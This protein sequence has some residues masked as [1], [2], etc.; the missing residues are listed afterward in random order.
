MVERQGASTGSGGCGAHRDPQSGRRRPASVAGWRGVAAAGVVGFLFVAGCEAFRPREPETPAAVDNARAI[1]REV[2]VPRHLQDGEEYRVG[3]EALIEHGRNLFAAA[4]TVE[5]GGGRPL[6][7]GTGEQLADRRTPLVFPRGFNRISGMDANSCAGCHNAPFG[8]AAGG[9]D[10]VTNVFVLGQ[11]FDFVT[12][13]PADTVPTRG[14]VDERGRPVTLQTIGNSRSTLGMFGAGF[15][16]MLAR[17]ITRDLQAIRDGTPPG[18]SRPLVSKGIS[19]G[20]IV[21]TPDGRWDASR[22][23]GLPAASVRS[24]GS[25]VPPSL[26]IRPFHQA[27]Q[28]VSLRE[29]TNTAFNHHHG[30][31]STERFGLD[32]DPDGDGVR[33]ELTRADVTAVTVFQATLQVPGR[34]IPDDP[35]IERAVL[36]G[37]DRFRAIGCATCHVPS[38]PLTREGWVFTEPSPFNLPAN[39]RLGEAPTL[40][41]DLT[42]SRL[43]GPRL[44]PGPDGVVHVPAFT[45][46]KLH[47]ITCGRD[48][49]NVE[50][51]DMQMS[52]RSER[53]RAGNSR[54]LT[55]KLWGTANEPPFFHHG[56]FTTLKEAVLAHCGEALE[57][58]HAFQA[59]STYERGAVIEFLKS[60]RVLPPGTRHLVVNERNAKKTWPVTA[61][62]Q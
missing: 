57:T 32:T 23:L 50:R 3:I 34:V 47:D 1:G 41:V 37:E 8:I 18:E 12:F 51:L 7:K 48:D 9:G 14:A 55:R 21:R 10:F 19:F 22:V 24:G 38:L 60:L 54:F 15:I 13:D 25:H 58:R 36:I 30:I 29:F 61:R 62:P 31:Q 5:D 49:P 52:P 53:F 39:L 59:L 4:W 11:R 35:A 44:V 20:T 40:A 16:E 42:G 26:V 45:D 33:N 2:A 27:G 56:Q 43:P 28:V 17:Q 6:S 46:L